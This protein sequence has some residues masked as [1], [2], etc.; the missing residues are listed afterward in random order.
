MQW[1]QSWNKVPTEQN[2]YISFK[3]FEKHPFCLNAVFYKGPRHWKKSLQI[4][5]SATKKN[6][7]FCNL[8]IFS[9]VDSLISQTGCIVVDVCFR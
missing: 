8:H 9:Q 7:S 4:Q 5:G 2:N 1:H 3:L 6:D